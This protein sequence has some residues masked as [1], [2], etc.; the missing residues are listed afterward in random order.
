MEM[1]SRSWVVPVSDVD[2]VRHFHETL[3]SGWTLT[4]SPARTSG[5]CGSER[6]AEPLDRVHGGIR[7]SEQRLVVVAVVG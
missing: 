4:G 7:M 3:R 5:W 1:N 2:R 6:G